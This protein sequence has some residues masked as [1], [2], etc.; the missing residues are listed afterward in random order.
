MVVVIFRKQLHKEREESAFVRRPLFCY[1]PH[2]PIRA[3]SRLPSSETL[4]E[5]S[6]CWNFWKNVKVVQ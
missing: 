3:T 1:L 2:K 6:S 4:L 5:R